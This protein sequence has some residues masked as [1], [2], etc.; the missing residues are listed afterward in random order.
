MNSDINDLTEL[1]FDGGTTLTTT[2]SSGHLQQRTLGRRR[3]VPGGPVADGDIRVTILGSGDPFVN[4][5]TGVGVGADRGRQHAARLLLLRPRLRGAG[6]LQRPAPA[7]H[8]PPPRCS[9]PTYTPTTS[10][11]CP[12]WCG[13]WPR[14]GVATRS[15]SGG[16][17]ANGQS[18]A[19]APTPSTWRPPMRGTP[20]SLNGHPGQSG[21]RTEVSE[22]PYDTTSVVYERNGVRDLILPRDPHPQRLGWVPAWTT[23]GLSVVFSGDTRPCHTLVDACDGVDLLIHETFPRRGSTREKAG[24]PL[25]VRRADRQRGAHQPGRRR[26]RLRPRRCA[27]VGDVAPRRRPRDGRTGDRRDAHPARRAGHHR[28]GPHPFTITKDAIITGRPP[29]TRPPG[30]WSDRPEITGPPMSAPKAPPA[31]WADALITD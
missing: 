7:R 15:R 11:T 27:H 29:S 12:R 3:V 5:L 10:A 23:A 18:W 30:R 9:S 19:P 31:W 1:A 20:Q 13:A 22:V 21:A 6:Q 14:P 8:R 25:G 17:P 26:R 24:V 4:T 2:P 28:P 16:R